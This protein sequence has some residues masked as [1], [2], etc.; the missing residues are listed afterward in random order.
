MKRLQ[1]ASMKAK[2]FYLLYKKILR[3]IKGNK[4]FTWKESSSISTKH[5]KYKSTPLRMKKTVLLCQSR[6]SSS[7]AIKSIQD[8]RKIA[9][10]IIFLHRLI[11]DKILEDALTSSDLLL[12]PN[13]KSLVSRVLSVATSS[14]FFLVRFSMSA[15]G[16]AAWDYT[17]TLRGL[18]S[19]PSFRS[20]EV[21]ALPSKILHVTGRL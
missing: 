20:G 3:R 17:A 6:L 9:L 7:H 14:Y 11:R 19:P 13:T 4:F 2:N 8:H 21:Q 5:V 18:P 10:K 16:A 15:A 12:L 1:F